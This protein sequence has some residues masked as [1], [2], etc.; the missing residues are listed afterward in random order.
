[1]ANDKEITVEQKLR[2]LYDLQLIDTRIDKIRAVRGELPLEVEDLEDE[3]AGLETRLNNFKQEIADLD[4]QIKEKKISIE[5]ADKLIEKYV[6]QQKNVRNNREYDSL[7]KEIEFQG[8]EKELAQKR[9][10]EHQSDIIHKNQLIEETQEKLDTR[11]SH[12][13]HKKEELDDILAETQKEEDL[14][15]EK[16]KEFGETIDD[17]LLEAYHRI[18]SSVIN[19]LAIVSIER[20]ASIGSFFTI[21]PQKQMEVAQRKKIIIDEH[22]GRILV[23]PALAEEESQKMNELFG[24]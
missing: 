10:G 7:S 12:L 15:L 19:G 2:A 23:D 9:I 22:S 13:K 5:E 17:R 11:K 3:I 18:R 16:S 6:E 21:P 24:S 14:L 20:G 4:S 8:L 1:M